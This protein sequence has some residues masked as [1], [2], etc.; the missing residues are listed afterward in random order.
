MS[1]VKALVVA[2]YQEQMEKAW[3]EALRAKYP[4]EVNWE[5]I[6]KIKD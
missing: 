5:L 4:V 3:V 6:E 2:D 1:D